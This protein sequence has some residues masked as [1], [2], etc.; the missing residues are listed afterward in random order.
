MSFSSSLC[1]PVTVPRILLSSK[2]LSFEN[3]CRITCYILLLL[4]LM[5][6]AIQLRAVREP[7]NLRSQSNK[8]IINKVYDHHVM[9]CGPVYFRSVSCRIYA[10]PLNL[11]HIMALWWRGDRRHKWRCSAQYSAGCL[12][13]TSALTDMSHKWRSSSFSVFRSMACG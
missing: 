9:C 10:A 13:L 3:M 2:E 8:V 6:S 4:T 7:G 1:H 5:Y 11:L 12:S